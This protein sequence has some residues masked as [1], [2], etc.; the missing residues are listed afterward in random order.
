MAEDHSEVLQRLTTRFIQLGNEMT[1]EGVT[2][3]VVSVA[4]MSASGYYAT[5]AM[6]GND[7]FLNEKGVERVTETFKANLE[8]VQAYKK[9]GGGDS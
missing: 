2:K 7:G 5:Y 6:A 8:K 3:E 1:N 9:T 4:M